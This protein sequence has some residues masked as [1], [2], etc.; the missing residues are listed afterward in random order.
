MNPKCTKQQSCET[1]G[2][3]PDRA[4]PPVA[5]LCGQ[6]RLRETHEVAGLWATQLREDTLHS[7]DWA[8]E[9]SAPSGGDP[10]LLERR[11]MSD[12]LQ[13]SWPAS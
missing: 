8:R 4:L 1:H 3:E 11:S 2:S 5:P 13:A 12:S 10:L 6:V 7:P 9:A